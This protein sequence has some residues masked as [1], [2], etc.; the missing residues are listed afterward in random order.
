MMRELVKTIAAAAGALVFVA[1]AYAI[2]YVDGAPHNDAGSSITWP[3]IVRPNSLIRGSIEGCCDPAD[4]YYFFPESSGT[5]SV[6][7]TGL[8]QDLDLRLYDENGL[9][10]AESEE[11]G[12]ADERLSVLVSAGKKYIVGVVP[13]QSAQSAYQVK[14]TPP[15]S[16]V[17]TVITPSRFY[18]YAE[19]AYPWLF[20]GAPNSGSEL[21]Y[22]YRYYPSSRN[23][24]A[25]DP[26]GGVFYQGVEVNNQLVRLGHMN[27]FRSEIE[28][29]EGTTG[30]P[31]PPTSP[32]AGSFTLSVSATGAGQGTV[33]PSSG[34]FSTGTT[35]TAF[36]NPDFFSEFA[37][38]TSRST[39]TGCVGRTVGC[40][41][42]MN[43]NH[44]L[45]AKFVQTA[46]VTSFDTI[47]R[48]SRTLGS[49]TCS[50]TNEWKDTKIEITRSTSGGVSTQKIRL[51][52][53]ES[54]VGHAS[55]CTSGSQRLDTTYVIPSSGSVSG[56]FL[57]SD[58]VGDTY[59][60]LSTT[61]PGRLLSGESDSTLVMM[62]LEYTNTP[63]AT[64]SS[65][66]TG[67]VTR[68]PMQ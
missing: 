41:F 17:S 45:E 23:Y 49:G 1:P 14:L 42:S 55:N 30:T 33:T 46:F 52:G 62:Q 13:Y 47:F 21:G 40:E 28:R 25:L 19:R 11:V 51:T 9:L 63:G 65:N 7:M 57:I 37:G 3:T 43:Q 4:Y 59:L 8:A 60:T 38:W 20:V 56:R 32:S 36:A 16:T 58:G 53:T 27:D 29:L 44:V 26:S 48:T 67:L 54:W 6:V 61:L 66:V 2:D 68:V 22:T 35:V 10:L 24:L 5:L 50:W 15:A 34:T 18:T 64:G 31:P 39:L 12:A